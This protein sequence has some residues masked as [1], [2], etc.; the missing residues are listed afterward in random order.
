MD[1]GLEMDGDLELDGDL[2]M[3]LIRDQ[4][5]AVVEGKQ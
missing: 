2:E 1:L 5:V 3:E 4:D